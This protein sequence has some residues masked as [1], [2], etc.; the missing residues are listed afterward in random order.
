MAKGAAGAVLG[1]LF[2][3]FA[4]WLVFFGGI[5]TL[6][7]LLAPSP[8]PPPATDKFDVAISAVAAAG[9]SN[10]QYMDS[11]T[12]V[13][14]SDT[15][16]DFAALPTITLTIVVQSQ[17]PTAV[18]ANHQF[19]VTVDDP[20]VTSGGN[21]YPLI[22]TEAS[23]PNCPSITYANSGGSGFETINPC[24]YA[25]V[26][27]TRAGMTLSLILSVNS[28]AFNNATVGASYTF[29]I[30]TSNGNSVQA[31]FQITG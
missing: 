24:G 30:D 23:S 11:N 3:L 19:Q 25:G 22:S 5:G 4:V 27:S 6:Q 28:A 29:S 2:V 9:T 15:R 17:A 16:A 20:T 18:Q 14:I 1:T 31:V 21:Q 8:S 12:R 7:G 26:V 10:V 13:T